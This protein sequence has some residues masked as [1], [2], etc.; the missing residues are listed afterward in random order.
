[1]S[2]VKSF[3]VDHRTLKPG[4][5]LRDT[6]KAS[7]F[8]PKVLTWDLRLKEPAKQEFIKGRSL[9]VMEHCLAYYLRKQVIADEIIYVGPMGCCTGMYILTTSK[10]TKYMLCDALKRSCDTIL[11]VV[12]NKVDVPGMNVEQCGN[13]VYANVEDALNEFG[14]M[15]VMLT[16]LEL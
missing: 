1:M 10:V 3:S 2:K 5:Y 11:G 13:P 12:K 6:Y 7:F 16:N 4:L 8:G 9:H 15:R 14:H